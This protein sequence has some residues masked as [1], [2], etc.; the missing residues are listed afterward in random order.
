MTE[1]KLKGI[2][3]PNIVPLTGNGEINE[4]EFRRYISWLIEKG[5][6]G[7]YPN[8]STGE[9][10]R[11]SPEE[12]R[13]I[14]SIVTSETNGRVPVMAGASEANIRDT[15]DA[16]T[17]YAEMGCAVVAIVPPYYYRLSQE[18]VVEHFTQIARQS[19]IDIMLYNI[20]SFTNEISIESVVRLSDL[21]RIV[22]IKDSSRDLPRFMNLMN[23]IRPRR[24]EFTFLTGTEEILMASLLMGADGGTI[25]TSGVVPEVIMK[26]YNLTLAGELDEARRIQFKML[27]L[28][29]IMLFGAGFPDG[30]KAAIGLRGFMVGPSRQPLSSKEKADLNAVQQTLHCILSTHGFVSDVAGV[31]PIASGC[32]PGFDSVE[33]SSV[34]EDIVQKIV[35][36]VVKQMQR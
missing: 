3:T 29:N 14:V 22:G 25:A 12:R 36:E 15:L 19:P 27:E 6:S 5:V 20:P 2:F 8:G 1:P 21:P 32:G 18:S 11:F 10:T 30:F 13:R 26:L 28:I 7:L 33:A 24:P 16:C 34:P 35:A 17:A 23:E 4:P 9:F 31:P